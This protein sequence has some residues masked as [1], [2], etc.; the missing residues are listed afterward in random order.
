LIIV[1]SEG[2]TQHAP[3]RQLDGWGQR[4]VP[5]PET[6]SRVQSIAKELLRS[7]TGRFEEPRNFDRDALKEVHDPGLLSFLRTVHTNRTGEI[8]PD[9]VCLGPR[10][11]RPA[12]KIGQLGYYCFDVQTPVVEGTWQAAVSSAETALTGA[13]RLAESGENVYALC[14]PSGHH[15]G[16]DYYGG[17]CYLN[18]AAL[19]AN[20]LAK[21]GSVAILDIDYH[22]GNG[23]QDIFYRRSDVLFVSIHADPNRAYPYFWG[24]PEETGSEDGEGT[25]RNLPLPLGAEESE[26]MEAL[27]E[28]LDAIKAFSPSA[29]VVSLGLDIYDGDPIG[30]FNLGEGTFTRIGRRLG[31][32]AMPTLVV[33][34]G[35]YNVAVAGT[36]VDRFLDGVGG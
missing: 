28:G 3:E 13:A 26:Y 8:V 29:L 22:H 1:Y 2:H 15:A 36:L 12:S 23:T 27:E 31:S 16:P 10:R 14:R 6:P 30:R 19:A 24:Y 9:V 20:A 33:Q 17:Y 4:L 5:Y 34:E 11:V 21:S 18:N 25:N 7:E 32:L 35:G